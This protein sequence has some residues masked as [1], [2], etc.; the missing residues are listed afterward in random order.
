MSTYLNK[1]ISEWNTKDLAAWL[2]DNKY[3]G[4]SELCQN[5]SLSGYDLF[6]INDDILKNDLGLTSFHERK[7]TL[8]LINKL[9]N[10]HLK[11]NII[12]SNG[13][14]VILT[15]DNNHDTSL[16]ELSEYIGG[17]FNM[18]PKDILYK[19][20]TKKEVLSPTLKI[21]KL[22]ILYPKLYKTL[23]VFNMKDYYQMNDDNVEQ[24][25]NDFNNI[26]DNNNNNAS[27]EIENENE[28]DSDYQEIE[29]V[30]NMNYNYKE[31]RQNNYNESM[32]NNNNFDEKNNREK[33]EEMNQ[34]RIIYNDDENEKNDRIIYNNDD[35]IKNKKYRSDQRIY[36]DNKK[37]NMQN[38]NM[39]EIDS[40]FG[41]NRI[42]DNYDLK[43]RIKTTYK[44]NNDNIKMNKDYYSLRN[45]KKNLNDR[46]YQENYNNNKLFKNMDNR[47]YYNNNNNSSALN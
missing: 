21:I 29:R 18:E 23:N 41:G 32:N 38:E 14:N 13:D 44:D 36:R 26:N 46:S 3:P 16:G 1:E 40:D 9:I 4:I 47:D 39:E 30:N 2:M 34:N 33:F 22:I 24:K 28:N 37:E 20:F 6:F 25:T 35:N 45:K 42:M 17:M 31:N 43:Y 15:L 10:E 27:S 7:V 11:L 12:N 19:D 8:K 5:N